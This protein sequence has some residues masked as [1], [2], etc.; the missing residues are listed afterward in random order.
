MPIKKQKL[1]LEY[2]SEPG[3]QTWPAR[4]LNNLAKDMRLLRDTSEVGFEPRSV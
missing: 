2:F 1:L 4:T 3:I